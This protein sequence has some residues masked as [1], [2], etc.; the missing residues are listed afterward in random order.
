MVLEKK[1]YFH[2]VFMM[3]ETENSNEWVEWIE[4]TINDKQIKYYEYKYFHEVKEIAKGGFTEV[5]RA[6]W[7]SSNKY[8]ALK[9]FNLNNDVIKNIVGEVNVIYLI[10]IL[11]YLV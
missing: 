1:T 9:S 8:F 4:K 7:K 10:F 5:Y 3:S 2:L 6:K 11:R